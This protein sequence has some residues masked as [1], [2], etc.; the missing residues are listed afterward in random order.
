MIITIDDFKRGL[1]PEQL[2]ALRENLNMEAAARAIREAGIASY[3]APDVEIA[4][5]MR[6]YAQIAARIQRKAEQQQIEVS[7]V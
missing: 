3:D 2:A 5:G 1:K 7:H 6:E 4:A